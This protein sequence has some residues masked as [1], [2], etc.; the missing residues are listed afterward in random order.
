MIDEFIKQLNALDDTATEVFTAAEAREDK[1]LTDEE[2]AT[3]LGVEK[4]TTVVEAS[5]SL[6]R[7]KEDRKNAEAGAGSK[8]LIHG[9]YLPDEDKNSHIYD[10]DMGSFLKDVHTASTGEGNVGHISPRLEQYTASVQK[11]LAGLIGNT[12]LD[13]AAPTNSFQE[14]GSS[15]G[16]FM[17]PADFRNMVWEVVESDEGIFGRTNPSPTNSNM[18]KFAA[19]ESTPWSADFIQA[20]WRGELDQMTP[21]KMTTEGRNINLHEIFAFV[22]ATDAILEDTALLLERITRKAPIAIRFKIDEAIVSGDGVGKPLGWLNAAYLGAVLVAKESG[23]AADTVVMSNISKMYQRIRPDEL[24]GYEWQLNQ[25]VFQQLADLNFGNRVVYTSPQTGIVNAPFGT[26]YGIPLRYSQHARTLGDEG[27]ISLVNYRTGYAS[28]RRT[29]GIQ[30]D[31]S[32]HLWFDYATTAFRWKTRIGGKPFLSAPVA[33]Q[34]GS[35]TTAHF[36]KLAARS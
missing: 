14:V 21:S 32:I 13:A 25:D 6:L 3:I 26:L 8:T 24:A 2:A 27:D 5:L 16:G 7:S 33:P 28:Y 30:F 34:F 15:E 18:V 20:T 1:T 31:T 9:L 4:D 12:G 19:D 35:N 22:A 23:Q 11:E 29:S 10:K 17:V 36:I